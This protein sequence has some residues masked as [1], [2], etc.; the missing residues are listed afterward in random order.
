MFFSDLMSRRVHPGD[1]VLGTPPGLSTEP[2]IGIPCGSESEACRGECYAF[3]YEP[4]R[5]N[6]VGHGIFRTGVASMSLAMVDEDFP[7]L[8]HQYDILRMGDVFHG[9]SRHD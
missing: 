9:V 1:S 6:S 5:E 8:H 7:A 3:A 4:T 2:V